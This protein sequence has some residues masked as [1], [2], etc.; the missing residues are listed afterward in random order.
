MLTRASFTGWL[1]VK[2]IAANWSLTCRRL[3]ASRS[4]GRTSICLAWSVRRIGLGLAGA[5]ED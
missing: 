2:V 5:R 3:A 1:K 4:P